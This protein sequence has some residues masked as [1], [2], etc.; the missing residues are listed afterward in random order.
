M[1]RT[2]GTLLH[3][4]YGFLK[5]CPLLQGKRK[6]ATAAPRTAAAKAAP[7]SPRP[8]PAKGGDDGEDSDGH[9]DDGFEMVAAHAGDGDEEEE[10]AQ[11]PETESAGA[12]EEFLDELPALQDMVRQAMR[13]D[14]NV[15]LRKQLADV[16]GLVQWTALERKHAE[17]LAALAPAPPAPHDAHPAP[18]SHVERPV[19]A[20]P[21]CSS[22]RWLRPT[23]WAVFRRTPIRAPTAKPAASVAHA[24]TATDA[25]P[26]HGFVLV[27]PPGAASATAADPGDAAGDHAEPPAALAAR[28]HARTAQAALKSAMLRC[29]DDMHDKDGVAHLIRVLAAAPTPEHLPPLYRDAFH[30]LR[31]VR[32]LVCTPL[33]PPWPPAFPVPTPHT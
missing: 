33:P 27:E 12:L 11:T 4:V 24:A 28:I 20:P 17:D 8:Q 16:L 22:A 14:L 7:L 31:R 29:L 3:D 30:A 26:D 10:E 1:R 25:H 15:T 32:G 13:R 23:T 21:A 6:V 9:G 18:G 5:T 2:P 19:S